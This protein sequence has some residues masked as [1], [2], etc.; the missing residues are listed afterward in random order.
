MLRIDVRSHA[1]KGQGYY[2]QWNRA[3]DGGSRY[4]EVDVMVTAAIV[5]VVKFVGTHCSCECVAS[6]DIVLSRELCICIKLQWR[7]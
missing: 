3:N 6:F 7:L 2:S 5:S 1:N 4:D